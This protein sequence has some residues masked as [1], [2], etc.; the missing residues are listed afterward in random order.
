[1]DREITA[2]LKGF[3]VLSVLVSHY[4]INYFDSG[5]SF[6]YSI[7]SIFFVISGAGIFLSLDRQTKS[8][9]TGSG[10][11]GFFLKRILSIFP[12]YWPAYFLF[13]FFELYLSGRFQDFDFPSI[14]PAVIGAPVNPKGIFWFVTA[15][16][17]CYLLAP[18]LFV[19]IRKTGAVASIG[20][21]VLLMGLFS[22][23]NSILGLKLISQDLID[24]VNYK[25]FF[26]GNVILFYLGMTIPS[27]LEA[28]RL[29]FNNLAW[30]G[31]A[32]VFAAMV[33]ATDSPYTYHI[34][35]VPMFMVSA[36]LFCLTT[37]A[38]KPRLPFP[39]FFRLAGRNSY[40]LYLFHISF[41]MLLTSFGIIRPRSFVAA[42]ITALLF[43]FFFTA[44]IYLQSF[45]NRL[46]NLE[47]PGP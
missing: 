20:L 32:L 35:L 31:T 3:A 13:L 8:A 24:L 4:S 44:C 19:I 41:F 36:F 29:R 42:A 15:I 46:K 23:L 43:P 26:M 38:V 1:M 21:A 6:A 37:L 28:V 12:L 5:W 22:P 30:A 7:V 33:Y 17:Q 2:Y 47:L 25:N 27:L 45:M 9:G 40:P 10:F 14:M 39:A 18:L 34:Y 11:A 16:L